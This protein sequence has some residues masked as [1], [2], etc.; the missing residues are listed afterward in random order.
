MPNPLLNNSDSITNNTDIRFEEQQ[1][2]IELL[3]SDLNILRGL[4]TN[5]QLNY[6]K[7]SS[8]Y[9][10]L[11]KNKLDKFIFNEDKH[12]F[13]TKLRKF[14]IKFIFKENYLKD[15]SLNIGHGWSDEF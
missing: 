3:K 10:L 5:L 7:L 13:L 11:Y 15:F 2:Q 12:K 14:L 4:Y 9:E 6:N 1:E 8:Q